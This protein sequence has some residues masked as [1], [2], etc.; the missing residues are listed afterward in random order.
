MTELLK[1]AQSACKNINTDKFEEFCKENN[2]PTRKTLDGF[3]IDSIT[4]GAAI[5]FEKLQNKLK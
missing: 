3:Y 4:I 1:T 5:V 2:L